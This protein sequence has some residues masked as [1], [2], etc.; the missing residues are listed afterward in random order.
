MLTTR[1]KTGHNNFIT[2]EGEGESERGSK[3]GQC[4]AFFEGRLVGV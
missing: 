1:V 2:G 4:A 3:G